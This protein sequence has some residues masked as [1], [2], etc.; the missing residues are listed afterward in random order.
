MLCCCSRPG[1]GDADAATRR[2]T[3]SGAV[4][5]PE[6]VVDQVHMYVPFFSVFHAAFTSRIYHSI[7]PQLVAGSYLHDHSVLLLCFFY[8]LLLLLAGVPI[9][10]DWGVLFLCLFVLRIQCVYGHQ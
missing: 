5:D 7:H 4:D 1:G 3:V 6:A 9:N 2:T 8:P 10:Y